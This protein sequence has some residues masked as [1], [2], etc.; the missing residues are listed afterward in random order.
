VH[1]GPHHSVDKDGNVSDSYGADTTSREASK[2]TNYLRNIQYAT[3]DNLQARIRLHAKFATSPVEFPQWFFAQVD[4]SHAR[5][6]L[7]VGCGP[8]SIWTSLPQPLD[9]NLT[10]CDQSAGMIAAATATV[11]GHVADLAGVVASVQSLPF[12]DASFD[13]VIANYML[14]HATD[15]DQAVSELRRVLT[16]DGLL[17]AAT[18]GPAHLAEL[19]EIERSV[20]SFDAYR[21]HRQIFGSVSGQKYLEQHFGS[22]QWRDFED[23]LHCRDAEDVVAYIRSV[24]PGDRATPEQQLALR[25]EID[26]RMRLGHG[27]L[28]VTKETGAFFARSS[29]QD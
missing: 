7:D 2:Y 9:V 16:A 13:I 18:N 14:Y 15:I 10:L 5:H 8:G 11:R 17:V 29:A 19:V 3:P 23:E 12:A 22:V 28:R 1:L 26:E 24:P 25:R 20:L 21:D 4:W 6:V 27:V